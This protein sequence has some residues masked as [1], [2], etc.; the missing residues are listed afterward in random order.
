MTLLRL[1][2]AVGLTAFAGARAGAADVPG[3]RYGEVHISE[4]AGAMRGMV[5]LFSDLSGW[6]DTDRQAAE[7]LA[8]HDMLVVGV[9]TGSYA[10][11]LAGAT[12]A[13][14]HVDRDVEA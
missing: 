6:S 9:D 4:P 5:I 12:E 7:L 11:A 13:C 2:V 10:G 14:H 3:G 8:R 1:I